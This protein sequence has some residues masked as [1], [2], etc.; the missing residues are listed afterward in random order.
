M[1]SKKKI[2]K[3]VLDYYFQHGRNDL[4]WRKKITPYSI[5]VSEVMLQQTQV[6]RVH[7]KFLDWMSKYPNLKSLSRGNMSEILFLWKGLGYQRRAKFLLEISKKYKTI[8]NSFDALYKMPGIGEYTAS[9]LGAFA[10][11]SFLH[12]VL[13]TNI[14]TTLFYFFFNK[15]ETLVNDKEL[16]K[17]LTSL[18]KYK[19]VQSV[20]ARV[21]YYA[22]MDYGAHLKKQGISYNKKSTHYKKQTTYKGSLRELRAKV[23]FAILHQNPLPKDKRL[24]GV[25]DSLIKEGFIEKNKNNNYIIIS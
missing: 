1:V 24:V 14:R 12:P 4:P 8:P 15:S 13:E 19:E 17:I 9:A 25:L 23:L 22:L 11:N 21:W 6:E 20:G 16:K 2:I 10:F 5:L 18:E 7:K 3:I